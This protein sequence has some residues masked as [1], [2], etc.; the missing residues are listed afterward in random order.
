M[1]QL[2][3]KLNIS[4]TESDQSMSGTFTLVIDLPYDTTQR[5]LA[6]NH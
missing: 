4:D 5:K 2:R 3:E 6:N 1:E